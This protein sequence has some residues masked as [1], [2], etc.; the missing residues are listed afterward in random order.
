LGDDNGVRGGGDVS[1][2]QISRGAFGKGDDDESVVVGSG[3]VG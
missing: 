3:E 1:L 2:E